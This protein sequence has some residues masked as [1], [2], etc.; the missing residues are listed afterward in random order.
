MGLCLS[1]M[2]H[3]DRS[4]VNCRIHMQIQTIMDMAVS[5]NS[6]VVAME[7]D[8]DS[9]H[10]HNSTIMVSISNHLHSLAIS[11][12]NKADHRRNSDLLHLHRNKNGKSCFVSLLCIYYVCDVLLFELL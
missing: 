4:L 3:T 10:H 5:N 12:N 7:E 11:F 2:G 8:L 6:L 1:T 9:R